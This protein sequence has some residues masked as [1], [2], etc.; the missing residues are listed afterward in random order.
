MASGQFS[1]H[2]LLCFS[3]E[4]VPK[5][6]LWVTNFT[7]TENKDS[8]VLTCATSNA[9]VSIQWFLNGQNLKLMERRNLS[10]GNSNLTIHPV[11]RE[12]SGNYQCEVANPVSSSKSDPIKLDVI[13]E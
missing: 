5:P 6:S 7:V 4:P 10:Q 13:C 1:F 11:K 2:H 3:A 8:V 12:D 9:G